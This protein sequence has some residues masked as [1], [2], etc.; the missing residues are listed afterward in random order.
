MN[1]RNLMNLNER[2]E[3]ILFAAFVGDWLFPNCKGSDI[4]W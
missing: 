2:V 4:F 1:I 3:K